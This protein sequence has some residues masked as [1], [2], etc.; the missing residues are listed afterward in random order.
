VAEK[1][2]DEPTVMLGHSLGSIV[3]YNVVRDSSKKSIRAFITVGSPLGIRGISSSLE[4]P[5]RNIAGT[6]GWFN[7]YDKRDVVALNP[8]DATYF[9][10]HPTIVNDGTLINTTENHHGIVSYLD[11]VEVAR[12]VAEGFS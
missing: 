9:P 8:L 5:F 4:T 6:H 11:K 1:L 2:T 7:A 10:V 3:A 12:R